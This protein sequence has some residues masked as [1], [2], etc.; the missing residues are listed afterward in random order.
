MLLQLV[1][2][3]AQTGKCIWNNFVFCVCSPA[4][5]T[6][7]SAHHHKC[8]RLPGILYHLNGEKVINR[9]AACVCVRAGEA[10]ERFCYVL[11]RLLRLSL[12]R[13]NLIVALIFFFL[14]FRFVLSRASV[15]TGQQQAHCMSIDFLY[16]HNHICAPRKTTFHFNFVSN[17]LNIVL[18][19]SFCFAV[20]MSCLAEPSRI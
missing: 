5:S 10:T 4:P 20:V 6:L 9:L 16:A 12:M 19:F 18:L 1:R 2:R 13:N 7:Q 3:S 15:K 17:R 11:R 8:D 14:S